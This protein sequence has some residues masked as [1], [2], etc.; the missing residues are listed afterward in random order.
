M[1]FSNTSLTLI[2]DANGN[3]PESKPFDW[4]ALGPTAV[5]AFIAVCGWIIVERFARRRELRTDHRE[6]VKGFLTEVAAITSEA[7]EFY[8]I[9]GS[10]PQA[11][12][13]AHGLRAKI[14]GLGLQIDVMNSAG[15]QVSVANEL[16]EFRRA[17]TGGSFDSA[18]RAA[19]NADDPVF[20]S[21]TNAGQ[22]LS[23][24]VATK[25]YASL[26]H[27]RRKSG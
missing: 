21:I 11:V 26:S 18:K 1:R 5:T 9:K 19:S 3:R 4:L 25:F 10:D 17:V 12:R 8:Q 20:P 13:L 14:R 24:A 6:L 2:I 27:S 23:S 22:E 16:K 7:I 15:L